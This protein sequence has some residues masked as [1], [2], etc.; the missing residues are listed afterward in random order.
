MARVAS[1]ARR[2]RTSSSAEPADTDVGGGEE[3]DGV[4]VALARVSHGGA[5]GASEDERGLALPVQELA[6]FARCVVAASSSSDL[7]SSFKGFDGPLFS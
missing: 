7:S 4:D 6:N 1:P 3:R 5:A 2:G